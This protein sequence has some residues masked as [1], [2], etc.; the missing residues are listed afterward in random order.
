MSKFSVYKL[1]RVNLNIT[2]IDILDI[3]LRIL[4]IDNIKMNIRRS[5]QRNRSKILYPKLAPQDLPKINARTYIADNHLLR[6]NA[7]HFSNP[8]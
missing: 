8:P 7:N 1:A 6:A 4:P 5:T 3:N 2:I